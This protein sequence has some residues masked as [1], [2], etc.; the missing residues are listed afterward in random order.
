MN[1]AT[2]RPGFLNDIA[3]ILRLFLDLPAVTLA[4]ELHPPAAGETAIEVTLSRAQGAPRARAR[5]LARRGGEEEQFTY[6]YTSPFAGTTPLEIK[7]YEK[8]AAKIA[9]FR[10]M[11]QVYDAPTP[12]GSLTGIRPTHLYRELRESHGAAGAQDLLLR[13][14]DVSP[15]KFHLLQEI[16]AVQ[17]PILASVADK[18]VDVYIGVPFCPS[19]CLYCSFLSQVRTPKTDMAAYLS[20]LEQD[21]TLGAAILSQ[22]GYRLRAMYVGGGTPTVLTAQE[23]HRLL[24]HAL[25]AYNGFGREFTVEA[26]RPDSI[27]A[28]K[29]R[30]LK[31]LGVTRVCINPQTMNDETLARIGRRHTAQDIHNAFALARDTGFQDINMDLIA[32]LPGETPADMRAS[33]AAVSALAPEAVTVH[34]L[35]LK[36]A[37]DLVRTRQNW[38]LPSAAAVEEMLVDAALAARNMDLRP[39]YMYRQKY[40]RGNLENVGYAAPGRECLY[41]VDMMEETVNV[42][43]HGAGAMTKRVY[44]GERRVERLPAPKD[45]AAYC[46]KVPQLTENKR[47]LFC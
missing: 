21:I 6:E 3:E 43:A 26:G 18:D 8:R 41:N 12:W 27:S 36:R 15:A 7:R 44:G 10:A 42:M 31:R 14:F 45:I 33:L 19:R 30:V 32:G 11:K 40:M 24:S 47:K 29:L 5:L 9:A 34:T 35:A 37:S 16:N 20:A 1:V 17:A 4:P 39:Y 23:L 38:V 22:N 46:A 25:A 2:N 13:H 28:E